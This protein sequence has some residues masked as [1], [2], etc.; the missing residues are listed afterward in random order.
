MSFVSKLP[1]RQCKLTE[2]PVGL[3]FLGAGA[4]YA[5]LLAL[6]T[7]V[8][9]NNSI[10]ETNASGIPVRFVA[11]CGS[12]CIDGHISPI[13]GPTRCSGGLPLPPRK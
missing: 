12:G 6:N 1:E 13:V 3:N 9:P 2:C 8:D 4:R 10:Y 5:D 11:E 7:A